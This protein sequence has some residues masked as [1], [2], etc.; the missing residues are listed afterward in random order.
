MNAIIDTNA[1][2]TLRLKIFDKLLIKHGEFFQ[3]ED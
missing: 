3:K 2:I 1:K